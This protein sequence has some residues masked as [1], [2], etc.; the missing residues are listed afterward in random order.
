MLIM[1]MIW[2]CMITGTQTMLM[3]MMMDMDMVT[4][5]TTVTGINL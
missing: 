2:K 3:V 1:V 4:M 5:M